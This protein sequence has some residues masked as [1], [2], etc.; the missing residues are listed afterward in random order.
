MSYEP[1]FGPPIYYST[2]ASITTTGTTYDLN[3]L[4]VTGAQSNRI[5]I[6]N[7]SGSDCYVGFNKLAGSVTTTGA[8]ADIRIIAGDVKTFGIRTNLFSL[9]TNSAT[10][11]VDIEVY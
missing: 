7:T 6:H 10:A 8:T 1:L 3:S 9:K 5:K 4:A 11:T 2:A